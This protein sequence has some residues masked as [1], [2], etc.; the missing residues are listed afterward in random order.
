M[1]KEKKRKSKFLHV[2]V[3]FFFKQHASER[4]L[5]RDTLSVGYESFDRAR[6]LGPEVCALCVKIIYGR[7]NV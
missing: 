5:M 7:K 1:E 2:S 3:L 6:S 4:D